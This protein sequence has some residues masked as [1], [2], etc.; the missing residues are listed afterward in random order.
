MRHSFID[1][2]ANLDSP[3]HV[4]DARTKL[5]G[6]AALIIAVLLIP[7]GR[8]LVFFCYFFLIA[9]LGGFRR[10]LSALSFGAH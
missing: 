2:F 1:R 7:S 6:F 9:A 3:L 8:G 5:V 4:L 10:S